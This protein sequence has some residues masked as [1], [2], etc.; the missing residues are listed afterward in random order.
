MM[1]DLA[2]KLD[3]GSSVK[4]HPRWLRERANDP[5]NLDVMT[6]QRFYNPSELQNPG[7]IKNII[8]EDGWLDVRFEDGASTRLRESDLLAELPNAPDTGLPRQIPWESA[9]APATSIDYATLETDDGLFHA[10]RRFHQYG[11][12]ILAN[13]PCVDGTVMSVARKFGFARETNFGL[14]FDVLSKPEAEANDLSYTTAALAPHTDNP[15]REPVPGIQLLQC[16]VNRSNGG[17]STLVDGLAVANELRRTAPEAF[18]ALRTTKL[19]FRFIDKDTELVAHRPIIDADADGT[20]NAIHF[21]PRLD[22]VPLLPPDRLDQFF[23]AR[24]LI[25]EMLQ[26]PRFERKFM[27]QQ[28]ELQMFDNRR[29]L[30]GRTGYDAE[31]GPRHLQ[32]CYIDADAPRSRYRVLSR[33]L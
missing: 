13:V 11:F 4:L 29:L 23:A 9:E 5:Q 2:L 32:G 15:Y 8:R 3:D 18:E 6:Q 31:S 30:H 17:H 14:M 33:R 16:M 26:S 10:L 20:F 21:S 28:G 25:N 7:D 1:A 19:R 24:E 22:Y 27:L 12:V